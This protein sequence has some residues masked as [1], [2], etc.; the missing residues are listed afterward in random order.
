MKRLRTLRARIALSFALAATLSAVFYGASAIGVFLLHEVSEAEQNRSGVVID[1][2][3]ENATIVRRLATG[4]A[5]VAPFAAAGAALIGLW[6]AR[7]ALA[8]MRE[9][10]DRAR[11]ARARGE[12]APLP[13]HGTGDEW[14]QLATVVNDLLRDYHGA[15][16]R[17][18]AFSAN[19]A[20]E[21]R[22]PLTSMLGE[23]QVTL[24]RERT[25]DDYRAALR[26]VEAGVSHLARM[27]DHLLTLARADSGDLRVAAAGF[28]V[29]ALAATI[30]L[31]RRREQPRASLDMDAASAIASGDPILTRRVIENLV[32]NAFQHGGRVVTVSVRGADD[33]VQVSV[34]DDGPG[35]P[36]GVRARLFER[37]NREPGPS[38]GF[39]LGLA[40]AQALSLAQ[41]GRLSL[42]EASRATR[43]VL[44]LPRCSMRSSSAPTTSA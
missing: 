41:G 23:V 33:V 40:I 27:V 14:D 11:E 5:L 38:D 8:P 39:G 34:T 4:A 35:I 22:T 28:D 26:A 20:H 43:F 3:T 18:R 21:L 24:R 13:T 9:A 29:A 37:F 15:V 42:D 44:E 6:L 19:A 31:E 1:E 36:A 30:V 16:H 12:L 25:P 32:D 7:K 2:A 17:A 10:A